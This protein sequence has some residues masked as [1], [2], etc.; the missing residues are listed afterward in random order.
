MTTVITMGVHI[1]DVLGRHVEG[2][3]T[4]QNIDIIDEIRLT[5]AGTAAGTA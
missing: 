5:V 4:G 2:I 1:L 3:P